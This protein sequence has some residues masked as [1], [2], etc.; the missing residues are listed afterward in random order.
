MLLL[1]LNYY[2]VLVQIHENSWNIVQ[3]SW[4]KEPIYK[5]I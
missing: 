5:A 1:L 3:L 4:V 2:F